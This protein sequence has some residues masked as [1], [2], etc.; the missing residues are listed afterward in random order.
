MATPHVAAAA[1]LL[2]SNQGK[3]SPADVRARLMATAVKVKRMGGKSFHSDY[4]AGRLD[5]LRLLTM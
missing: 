2:L 4:G 1:A 5:L 3:M